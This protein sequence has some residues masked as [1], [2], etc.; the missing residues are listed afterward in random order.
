MD[1]PAPETLMRA[2]EQLNY[3]GA[4]DDEGE[5]TP[6]G[7]S[8]AE[9]PLDP[10]LGKMLVESP[11]FECSHEILTI[12]SMLSVPQVFLRP[13]GA[14]EAADSAKNQFAHADGDHLTLLNA[15]HAYRA[16]SI[17]GGGGGGGNGSSGGGASS[18]CY[19]NFL[20]IRTLIAAENVRTQ[21]QKIME[22][23]GLALISIP[24]TRK[25][26]Y[27]NIRK[28]IVAGFFQQV[29]HVER[30]G[31]YLT[32]PDNQVVAVHPSS[33]LQHKPEWLLYHEFVLTSKNFIRTVTP[34]RLD[35]L[36]D[37]APHFYTPEQFK[38]CEAKRKI[39]QSLLDRG[40]GGGKKNNEEG[41][42]AAG[43][44][45]GGWS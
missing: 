30:A 38:K 39:Q 34:I 43:G 9:F 33:V 5:M 41:R 36:L 45:G 42:G 3:L 8:M 6:L 23:L 17:G 14:T 44:G 16:H 13:R 26:Y 27:N 31:H 1:P 22:R 40:S 35:W 11:K 18:F 28:G 21:L 24:H 2:L 15:F 29:A 20:N 7:D 32:C 4:L 25:D 37:I 19:D 12:A 10:Q